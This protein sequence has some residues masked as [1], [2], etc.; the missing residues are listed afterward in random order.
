MKP[1]NRHLWLLDPLV[2]HPACVVRAMFGSKACY[3][4]GLLVLVL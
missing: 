4:N 3:F 2:E 1:V